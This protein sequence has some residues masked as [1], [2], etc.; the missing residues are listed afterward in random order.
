MDDGLGSLAATEL[1]LAQ[2][3]DVG[4][5]GRRRGEREGKGKGNGGSEEREGVCLGGACGGVGVFE[6]DSA[7]AVGERALLHW[8][9][10]IIND[11]FM[12]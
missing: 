5:C 8:L 1:A 9:L 4:Y 3:V 6:A 7:L 10:V 11:K 2:F 12:L